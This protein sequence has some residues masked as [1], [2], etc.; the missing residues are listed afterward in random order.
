MRKII[1]LK[2]NSE[3]GEAPIPEPGFGRPS[4]GRRLLRP[5]RRRT[6][7]M[8]IV[9]LVVIFFGW[10]FLSSGSQWRAV[11]LTNNQVYFG[12][13]REM[14]FASTITLTDVY[15]LQV[16]QSNQL[17]GSDQNQPAL[18]LVKLGNE[19]HGPTDEMVIPMAQVLFLE[20]LRSNS[21]VVTAIKEMQ[22]Q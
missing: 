4:M 2:E 13:F 5:L 19:I 16:N 15:Y 21:A 12:H 22:G 6:V 7:G 3:F 9:A 17:N 20:T 11:F 1:N 18:K 14:P 8:A 10:W